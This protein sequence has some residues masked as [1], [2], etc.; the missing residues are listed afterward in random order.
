[1]I[2]LDSG[3]NLHFPPRWC[4]NL[5][6]TSGILDLSHHDA[7]QLGTHRKT[8][9]QS[10]VAN[11]QVHTTCSL[12]R[13]PYPRRCL[14]H[15]GYTCGHQTSN[16]RAYMAGKTLIPCQILHLDR[17]FAA[18]NA[19]TLQNCSLLRCQHCSSHRSDCATIGMQCRAR[20]RR[21]CADEATLGGFLM[22]M[23]T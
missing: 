8:D 15:K 18:T 3:H 4:K 14:H 11:F 1:M 22:N 19:P 9:H 2:Q 16:V 7:I 23:L 5:L 10:Q 20:I 13:P 12:T 21:C 17:K 6:C